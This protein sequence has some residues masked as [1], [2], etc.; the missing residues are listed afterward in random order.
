MAIRLGDVIGAVRRRHPAYADPSVVPNRV[1]IEEAGRVQR[2]FALLA[3]QR[4]S[5]FLVQRAPI[6]LALGTDNRPGVVGVATTGGLPADVTAASATQA[7]ATAGA[8][9]YYD[10]D[11]ATV[12]VPAFAPTSV[13]VGASTTVVEFTGASRT[14]NAD[15]GL[16]LVVL[17]GPGAGPDA[18]RI[19]ASNTAD[20]WTVPNYGVSPTDASLF[21]LVVLPAADIDGTSGVVTQ[22]ASTRTR[23]GYLVK[24]DATGVAYLDLDT[25]LVALLPQGIPLPPLDRIVSLHGTRSGTATV[26]NPLTYPLGDNP[27]FFPVPVYHGRHQG[28][29]SGRAAFVEGSA[30]HLMGDQA[31][32]LGV[33][34]LVLSYVPIPPLFAVS[35]TVLDDYFLLPDPAYDALVG[36]L[37]VCA[38]RQAAARQHTVDVAAEAAEA[39]ACTSAW[40]TSVRQAGGRLRRMAVRNR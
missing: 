34:N 2:R 27:V 33:R 21:R 23:A 24:L 36:A 9:P 35:R 32:W 17:E 16:G 11:V 4:W 12:A 20:T 14:V 26:P 18:V 7:Q 8:A 40:L 15:V 5:G 6:Y 22:V 38:A 39:T 31:G 19:V 3:T 25:P 13:T 37:A 30:L 29:F 1:L 10:L 28:Q